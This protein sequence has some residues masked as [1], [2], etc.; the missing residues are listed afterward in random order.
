MQGTSIVSKKRIAV[1]LAILFLVALIFWTFPRYPALLHE[2]ERAERGTLTQRH[3]GKISKGELIPTDKAKDDIPT[4]IKKTTIN[5]IDTNE[6]GM[7]FG[8]VFGGAFLALALP[9]ATFRKYFTQTGFKGSLIGL[10]MGLPL[11]VCV[12]C[13]SPIGLS[14]SK[15]GA[16]LETI[17]STMITSPTLNLV[18]LF[19]VLTVF[20]KELVI[21]KIA[22]AIFLVLIAIPLIVKFFSKEQEMVA[23][24]I[25]PTIKFINESWTK[26]IKEAAKLF[27]LQTAKLAIL[28]IPLMIVAGIIGSILIVLFPLENFISPQHRTTPIVLAALLGTLLPIPTFVD[29]ILVLSLLQTGLPL[30]IAA[31]L[32]VTLPAYSI[33]A[34]SIIGRFISWRLAAAMFFITFAAGV[35][36]G[37]I[38]DKLQQVQADTLA[39][40][41]ACVPQAKKNDGFEDVTPKT[42]IIINDFDLKDTNEIYKITIRDMAGGV[43][44]ADFNNDGLVD[45]YFVTSQ[46]GRLFLNTGNLKF[47]DTTEKS[48][49][50]AYKDATGALAADFDNDGNIDLLLYGYRVSPRLYR[51]LG[52]A[53]FRDVTKEMGL[54]KA[55]MITYGAAFGDYNSDGWLDLYLVNYLDWTKPNTDEVPLDWE[56]RNVLFK[57]NRGSFENVTQ[58]A[59]VADR[60]GGLAVTFFDYN[61]DG[62]PD[63]LIANDFR[64]NTLFKNNHNGSFT[65][66]SDLLSA[67]T[68]AINHGMGIALADYANHGFLDAYI[69]NIYADKDAFYAGGNMLFINKDGE[70]LA[71]IAKESKTQIGGWGWG[72]VPIDY[73]NDGLADIAQVSGFTANESLAK[74]ISEMLLRPRAYFYK[75]LGKNRFI[76]KACE[77]G[78]F[79]NQNGRGLVVADLD[80]DGY[81]DLIVSGLGQQP[82]IFHNLGG[83]NNWIE[84][85][86]IGTKSNRDGIGTK[87]WVN[88][89]KTTQLKELETSG[90]YLSSSDLLVHFGLGE[91]K[92]ITELRILWPSGKAQTLKNVSVNQKITISEPELDK[93]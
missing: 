15:K 41:L 64:P 21:T 67:N 89:G 68:K 29:I 45:L 54:E 76:E 16:S 19:I 10:L 49:I 61:K 47:K 93:P 56:Q 46:G 92:T 72:V 31:A 43:V 79:D 34:G 5:W 4:L 17:L 80:N 39:Q 28:T 51:N 74:H 90:T 35:G 53:V 84:V 33:F 20:P 88:N 36:T 66:V 14:M 59:G 18:G 86:L 42:D 30:G 7:A 55:G 73:D 62:Y 1:G 85:K 26:A 11:G 75:N 81:L 23:C 12:N 44:A 25:P 24:N 58:F 13:I 9:L 87:V 82:R 50:S 63:I 65:N 27:L 6:Y 91:S 3:L 77:L 40:K 69:S 48:G 2:A 71:N 57:N 52:N 78:F 60:G 37:L 8:I 22:S 32:L 38:V 70:K 83:K